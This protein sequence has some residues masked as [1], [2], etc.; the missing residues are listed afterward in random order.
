[1]PE[2][3]VGVRTVPQLMRDYFG[4]HRIEWSDDHSVE[5][6]LPCGKW[7]ELFGRYHFTI[8]SLTEPQAPPGPASQP[9]HVTAE[10]A[11]RWPSEEIWRV[12]K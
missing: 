1:M 9:T 6:A 2:P 10:W 3:D 8:E 7:I 4:I 11:R 5:F 12:R